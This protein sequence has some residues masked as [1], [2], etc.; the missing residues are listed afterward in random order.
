M[1]HASV[2]LA[3]EAFFTRTVDAGGGQPAAEPTADVTVAFSSNAVATRVTAGRST[4]GATPLAV[5]GDAPPG[6]FSTVGT[7]GI[8]PFFVTL[9]RE[10]PGMFSADVS[11]AYTATELMRAGIVP[12]SSAEAA[13][14]VGTFVGGA[15]MTGMAACAEDGDCGA[16]GP[17]LGVTYT[18]LPT[19]I[20]TM[21]HVATAQTSSFSTF[22]VLNPNILSG[23][24][25][26]PLVPGGGTAR[27]DC[28]AEWEVVNPT[29]MPALVDGLVSTTQTCTDGDLLCDGDA[30]ADGAC[31]FRVAI[32]LNESDASLPDCTPSETASVH[33][34]LGR[35]PANAGALLDALAALGGTRVGRRLDRV[36]FTPALSGGHCTAFVQLS[37]P[38]GGRQKLRLRATS[39]ARTGDTDRLRLVCQ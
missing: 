21:A 14:A 26:V 32:C 13:L 24:P 30:A 31:G 28:R 34:P 15:C 12:G 4:L 1:R 7:P 36:S 29:N 20:D 23:A 16:N 2:L 19:A 39:G 18:I 37:V 9:Q 27:S 33:I 25:I 6:P 8:L 35:T 11:I 38:K 17:C 22:A 3:T 5:D 10:L